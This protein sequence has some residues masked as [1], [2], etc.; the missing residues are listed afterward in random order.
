MIIIK[1]AWKRRYVLCCAHDFCGRNFIEESS[2]G[3]VIANGN[4]KTAR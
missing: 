2:A 1:D 4:H 3:R